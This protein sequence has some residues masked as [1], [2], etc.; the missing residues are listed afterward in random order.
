MESINKIQNTNHCIELLAAQRV[1]YRE[2]KKYRTI[3]I[4]GSFGLTIIA[5]I[6]ILFFPELKITLGIV[7]GI[8]TI[9]AFLLSSR[10]NSKVKEAATIQEEFDTQTFELDWNNIQCGSKM[11]NEII[12]NSASKYNDK[13]DLKD[14]YGDLDGITTNLSILICQRSN[15]VW[16][17]RLRRQFA[18]TIIIALLILFGLGLGISLYHSLALQTYLISII[19]PSASAFILGIK[20]VKEHFDSAKSKEAL[21]KK[22]NFIWE[23]SMTSLVSPT[24]LDLR[25]VQDKIYQLRTNTALIPEWWYDTLKGD[26]EKSMQNTID[27]YRN[28]AKNKNII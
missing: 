22:I 12:H 23:K 24:K 3:R 10:E 25:Q 6:V 21:E 20:E 8:W 11:S 18:W 15:L 19:L 28:E 16:D 9:V 4:L 26:F 1:I 5:P 14:W 13:S 27:R 2:A 7:G 17:W